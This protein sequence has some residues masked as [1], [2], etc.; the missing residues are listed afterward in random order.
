MSQDPVAPPAW[1]VWLRRLAPWVITTAVL[2]VLLWKY[3]LA[4][5][6]AEMKRGDALAVLPLGLVVA[7]VPLFL[8][9]AWDRLIMRAAAGPV[10]YLDVLVGKAGT[11]L[12][13][14]LGYGFGHGAYGVWLARKTGADARTT[15]GVILYIVLSDLAAV[16]LVAS[17]ALW[18]S[19]AELPPG[20]EVLRVL[21]PAAAAALMIVAMAGPRLLAGWVRDPRVLKPWAAV[22]PPVYLL[23]VA[24]RCL[25]ISI[26]I[27]LTWLAAGAFGLDLP[28]AVAASYLP[29]IML[30]AALPINVAGLGAVQVVWLLFRP[31]APGEQILAFQFLWHLFLTAGLIL[32]GAPFIRR[33][34]REIDGGTMGGR[35]QRTMGGRWGDGVNESTNRGRI[36]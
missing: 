6:G 8:V 12:L 7:L 2:A 23:S 25:I 14:V 31:W 21:A 22:T 1:R 9:A 27:V 32:R 26:V 5:I 35:S 3:P 34:L 20:G 16:C 15:V 29:V 10:G 13:M 4:R 17:A 33:V 28:L 24:G 30:V 19:G 11:S 36:S 18:L